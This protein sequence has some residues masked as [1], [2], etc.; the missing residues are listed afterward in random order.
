MKKVVV[1]TFSMLL[2]VF[3]L[4]CGSTAVS[5]TP[6]S[7]T[8]SVASL[9]YI[10]SGFIESEVS[11]LEDPTSYK[12]T[13]LTN[14]F[15][16]PPGTTTTKVEGEIG[17]VNI[18]LDKLKIFMDDGFDA[19]DVDV[20]VESDD[21]EYS[22]MLSYSVEGEL[23][24]IYYN[25]NEETD[26]YEG[27]LIAGE[28]TYDLIIEDNLKEEDNET[29]RNLVLTATNGDNW[30]KI[31]YENKTEDDESK[32]NLEVT[33]FIEG[34]QSVVT[35]EIKQEEGSFKVSIEDGENQFDFKA[36]TTDEGIHYKLDYIVDGIEGVAKIDETVDDDGNIIYSYK[37]TEGEV[38]VTIEK[39]PPGQ[40]KD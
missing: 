15:L 36:E 13:M 19:I 24:K 37:I 6:M 29:K 35:I 10:S 30:I 32:E 8:S 25:Y 9:S 23:F 20:E 11:L 21:S 40:N 39:E 34:E 17:Y 3:T 26:L 31:D 12:P 28:I 38:S 5:E 2:M 1:I 22:F 33:K 18:Y 7:S 14:R 16:T 4:S 27:I